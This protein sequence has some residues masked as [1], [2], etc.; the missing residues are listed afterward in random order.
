MD[1]L[2][3]GGV[4]YLHNLG[5]DF[6]RTNYGEYIIGVVKIKRRIHSLIIKTCCEFNREKNTTTVDSVRS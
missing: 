5:F 6:V 4:I 2:F 1:E 3:Y